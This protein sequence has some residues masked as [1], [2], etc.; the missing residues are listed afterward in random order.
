LFDLSL[1]G[2]FRAVS[3]FREGELLGSFE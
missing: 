1:L 3:K 2:L